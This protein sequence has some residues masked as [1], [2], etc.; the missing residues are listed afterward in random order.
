MHS[1]FSFLD[2][3]GHSLSLSG[4]GSTTSGI[5]GG[6]MIVEVC[7]I[8]APHL[9]TEMINAMNIHGVKE[10]S[11]NGEVYTIE[12]A[13][14]L[15]MLEPTERVLFD[16]IRDCNP[17][18]HV[19]EFVWMMAG[20]KDVGFIEKFNSKYRQYADGDHVHG[21]YGHRWLQ[22]FGYV[23]QISAVIDILKRDRSSRRAVLGM[24]DPQWDLEP[25]NDLPCNTHIYFRVDTENRLNMTVCNRS[26]DIIWGMLGANIVHMTYLHELISRCTGIP[27]GL[28]HV[29]SHNAHVYKELPKFKEIMQTRA[30]VDYYTDKHIEPYPLLR[31]GENLEMLLSDCH[32]LVHGLLEKPFTRWVAEVVLPM[33][34]AWMA[35]KDKI[36]DGSDEVKNIA[37]EDWRLACSEWINRRGSGQVPPVV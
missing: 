26:N 34:G 36:S 28:Y 23:N 3:A 27:L 14:H 10:Q 22:H 8:N 32:S 24:W 37:A 30:P 2:G 12:D 5:I 15:T 21:A 18:F 29:F 4:I 16:P 31:E 17:F 6:K 9:Y 33:Y 35:R 25:H 11:R 13:V 19:M 7:D 1:S 20:S